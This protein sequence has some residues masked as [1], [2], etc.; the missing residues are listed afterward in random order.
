MSRS[1]DNW[2]SS[3]NSFFFSKNQFSWSWLPRALPH[4]IPQTAGTFLDVGTLATAELVVIWVVFQP[5]QCPLSWLFSKLQALFFIHMGTS[6]TEL[7]LFQRGTTLMYMNVITTRV[8]RR[9]VSMHTSS[10]KEAGLRLR[11][12]VQKRIRQKTT[13]STYF[14]RGTTLMW[15]Q[16]EMWMQIEC[17]MLQIWTCSNVPMFKCSNVPKFGSTLVYLVSGDGAVGERERGKKIELCEKP[18]RR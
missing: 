10:C 13:F 14:Q 18:L 9:V 6:E 11:G 1:R 5:V 15:A 7:D 4:L 2:S 16:I 3:S 8:H 17:W 12:N